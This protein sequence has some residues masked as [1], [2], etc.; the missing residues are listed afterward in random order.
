MQAPL[1]SIP[2]ESSDEDEDDR[3]DRGVEKQIEE[4]DQEL[5]TIEPAKRPQL[6]VMGFL[7]EL[8]ISLSNSVGGNCYQ[9]SQLIHISAQFVLSSM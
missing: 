8:R 6:F 5:Q 1:L 2:S 7:Q 4:G 9:G 3:D